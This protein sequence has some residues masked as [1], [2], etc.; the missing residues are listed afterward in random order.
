M[1]LFVYGTLRKDQRYHD[2]YLAGR[3]RDSKPA[4]LEGARLD[5]LKD[6]AYPVLVLEGQG[7]V[8][9][10]VYEIAEKDLPT[11]DYL[12]GLLEKPP[13]VERRELKVQA[14]H[15]TLSAQLYVIRPERL[16]AL[17]GAVETIEDGDFVRFISAQE[18]H[19]ASQ[20]AG[21]LPY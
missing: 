20:A 6:L 8:Q 13:L 4:F 2:A 9:G 21:K 18:K 14:D 3:Y 16:E 17:A 7:S 19:E 1:W 10:E 15:E 11:L 12:E 5:Y